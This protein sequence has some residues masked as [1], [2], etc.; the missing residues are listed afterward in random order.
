MAPCMDCG[1]RPDEL[2]HFASGRHTYAEWQLFPELADRLVLCDFCEIDFGS[3]LPEYF[4]M[5]AGSEPGRRRQFIRERRDL[6]VVEDWVCP[7]CQ[8]RKGFAEF[9]VRVRLAFGGDAPVA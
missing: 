8:T 7:E 6:M 1:P 9:V 2:E 5:P 3:Y 4:G